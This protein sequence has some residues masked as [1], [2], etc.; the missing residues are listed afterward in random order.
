MHGGTALSQ[1]FNLNTL[2]YS[3]MFDVGKFNERF[4]VTAPSQ[5]P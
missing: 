5:W 4:Q 2:P 3:I 1:P